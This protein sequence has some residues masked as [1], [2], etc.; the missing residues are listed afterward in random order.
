MPRNLSN[1]IDI[2]YV[3]LRG[4]FVELTVL[5]DEAFQATFFLRNVSAVIN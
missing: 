5:L 4:T 3:V 2:F 1:F